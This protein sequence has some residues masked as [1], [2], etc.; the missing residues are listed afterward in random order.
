[1]TKE[2][3]PRHQRPRALLHRQRLSPVT[4]PCDTSSAS[5]PLY[6]LLSFF[7]PLFVCSSPLSLRDVYERIDCVVYFFVCLC[8]VSPLFLSFPIHHPCLF[9]QQGVSTSAPGSA[10]PTSG[11][12]KPAGP[13]NGQRLNTFVDILGDGTSTLR[14]RVRF[15]M[16]CLLGC[17]SLHCLCLFLCLS[18]LSV[19]W[20]AVGISLQ[21]E[22]CA[23]IYTL[24]I[25]TSMIS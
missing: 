20:L 10:S 13:P 16:G 4:L 17:L 12:P 15:N 19:C 14:S 3:V 23:L 9:S 6:F 18:V 2:R 25:N 24:Y 22:E 21:C 7:P 11:R 1:M 8:P 5:P